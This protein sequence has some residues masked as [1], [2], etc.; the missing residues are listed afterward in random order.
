MHYWELAGPRAPSWLSIA[1]GGKAPA[2]ASGPIVTASTAIVKKACHLNELALN[3]P[4]AFSRGLPL[5]RLEFARLQ[6]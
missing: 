2:T 4:A 6:G 3:Q 5:R 1:C